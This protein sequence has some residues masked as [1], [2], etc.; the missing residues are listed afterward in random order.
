MLTLRLP[1]SKTLKSP[2]PNNQEDL[3]K[4][5]KIFDK[6]IGKKYILRK[7]MSSILPPQL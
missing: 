3:D 1:F 6:D 5:R 4:I 7:E 2:F